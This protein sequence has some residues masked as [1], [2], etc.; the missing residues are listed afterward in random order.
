[1]DWNLGLVDISTIYMGTFDLV[2]FKVI[3]EPFLGALVKMV[4]YSERDGRRAKQEWNLEL[5][6]TSNSYIIYM[7]YRRPC[8]VQGHLGVIRCTCLKMAS[9]SKMAGSRAKLTTIC[10]SGMLATHVWCI[11]DLVGFRVILES[12]SA[13]ASKWPATPKRLVIERT[14][15]WDLRY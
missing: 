5:G 14:E 8:S 13:L 15:I 6:D 12:F 4:H 9:R 1:M 11:F 2:V 10:D 3:L 7:G